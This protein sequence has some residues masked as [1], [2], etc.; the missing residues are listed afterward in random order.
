MN[1]PNSVLGLV[2]A[3]ALAIGRTVLA[4]NEIMV[5]WQTPAWTPNQFTFVWSEAPALPAAAIED[6]TG[7]RAAIV[8]LGHASPAVL[9]SENGRSVA[10][11]G[12][13]AGAD[14]ATPF[15]VTIWPDWQVADATVA[16]SDVSQVRFLSNNHVLLWQSPDGGPYAAFV[17]DIRRPT[18]RFQF[19]GYQIDTL[20]VTDSG[21]WAA[22]ALDGSLS[23]GQ[24]NPSDIP[25]SVSG[26]SIPLSGTIRNLI[27]RQDGRFLLVERD[28]TVIVSL[29]S[30]DWTAVASITGGLGPIKGVVSPVGRDSCFGYQPE[31]GACTFSVSSG[32]ML[33]VSRWPHQIAEE[34]DVSLSPFRKFLITKKQ[35]D[36]GSVNYY[37]RKT[38]YATE[39]DVSP[40]WPSVPQGSRIQ[41]IGWLL[42]VP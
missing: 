23:S 26:A 11:T 21:K 2:V 5:G 16:F 19:S 1:L 34:G 14:P 10:A 12:A 32:G 4:Q 41:Q 24:F 15:G 28:D 38:P 13:K 8:A 30:T 27:W 6:L 20:R 31:V 7:L 37:Y 29:R 22:M 9:V 42:W 36:L 25:G 3:L 40:S 18:T 33:T 39:S 35:V 17:A